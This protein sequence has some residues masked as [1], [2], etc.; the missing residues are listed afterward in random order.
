MTSLFLGMKNAPS[1]EGPRFCM[2]WKTMF[3]HVMCCSKVTPRH[4]KRGTIWI[5]E[6]LGFKCAWEATFRFLDPKQNRFR[7]IF[8]IIKEFTCVQG[9]HLVGIAQ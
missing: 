1:T 2:Y 6:L 5:S 3:Q 7:F 9:Q 8:F 4:L